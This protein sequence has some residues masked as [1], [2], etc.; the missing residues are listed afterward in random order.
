MASSA[1]IPALVRRLRSPRRL[2][3]VQAAEALARLLPGDA[4]AVKAL[5]VTGGCAALAR[6]VV[7][8]SSQAAQRAAARA[9]NASNM[10]AGGSLARRLE[11]QAATEAAGS[12][13]ALVD[14]LRSSDDDMQEAAAFLAYLV[15]TISLELQSALVD[16]GGLPAL[17]GCLR[18][19]TSPGAR[20]LEY[21]IAHCSA[22][23]AALCIGKQEVQQ[24]VAAAGG[25]AVLVPLL[26]SSRALAQL[27]AVQALQQL[28]NGC[29]EGQQAAAAAGAIQAIAQLLASSTGEPA[30]A[31][32][33]HTLF[34]LWQHWSADVQQVA[35]SIPGLVHVLQH[36]SDGSDQQAALSLLY[37]IYEAGG[38]QELHAMAAAG[39]A[40]ALQRLLMVHGQDEAA[41]EL[42][43]K[44]STLLDALNRLPER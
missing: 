12:L 20:Q 37:S 29:P 8:G 3:Q 10:T 41:T 34:N 26:A 39:A 31:A 19:Q 27:G 38:P 13:P 28:T 22:T 1:D 16:A 6:M 43:S 7:S 40:P 18:Q 35:G 9:L 36:S 44:A 21:C 14:V 42:V 30:K 25:A 15:A 24:T 23:L 17:L 5:I 11:K 32:A 2:E 33:T 4:A